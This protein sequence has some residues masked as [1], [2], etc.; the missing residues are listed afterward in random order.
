MVAD[1]VQAAEPNEANRS[2]EIQTGAN[3]A[4]PEDLNWY[5]LLEKTRQAALQSIEEYLASQGLVPTGEADPLGNCL[6]LVPNHCM[7]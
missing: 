1:P 2:P 4:A 6:S 3:G 5:P 7:Q